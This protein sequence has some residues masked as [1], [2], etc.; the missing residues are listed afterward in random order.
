MVLISDWKKSTFD[1]IKDIEVDKV[2][3]LAIKNNASDIHL[4]VGRPPVF[5]IRGGLR[6]LEMPPI[7]ES[8]MIELT[9][10]DDGPAKS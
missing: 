8:Q 9:F 7:T 4:Q 3:R 1:P 2:F 10:P 5:R 6:D